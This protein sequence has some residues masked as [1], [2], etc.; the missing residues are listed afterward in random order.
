MKNVSLSSDESFKNL[1]ELE[2]VL[3][4]FK[5]SGAEMTGD[6]EE[7]SQASGEVTAASEI[8]S[9]ES[10]E[11]KPDMEEKSEEMLESL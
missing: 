7:S 9:G 8:T 4:E 11:E 6:S 1:T 2:N 5:T 10:E 3:E